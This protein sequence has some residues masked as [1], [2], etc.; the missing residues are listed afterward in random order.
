MDFSV[1]KYPFFVIKKMFKKTREDLAAGTAV[2]TVRSSKLG[3]KDH[4]DSICS[5]Q[6]KITSEKVK[7]IHTYI[8]L[9]SF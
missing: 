2:P 1:I 7:I 5:A 8:H 3:T 9:N 4:R 6:E